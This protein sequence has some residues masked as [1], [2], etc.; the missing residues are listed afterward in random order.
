MIEFS[1]F[2]IFLTRHFQVLS[3][4]ATRIGSTEIIREEAIVEKL[5]DNALARRHLGGREFNLAKS[6]ESLHLKRMNKLFDNKILNKHHERQMNDSR[7]GKVLEKHHQIPT[8]SGLRASLSVPTIST[9]VTHSRNI[10]TNTQ[11]TSHIKS[12]T[13]DY[14]SH[15]NFP[16]NRRNSTLGSIRENGRYNLEYQQYQYRHLRRIIQLHQN[17]QKFRE[18]GSSSKVKM[19]DSLS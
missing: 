16:H 2:D 6:Q 5:R 12:D 13:K 4:L 15:E 17:I 7:D 10:S 8:Q 3:K 19:S 9:H 11:C 14:P 1:F 18:S